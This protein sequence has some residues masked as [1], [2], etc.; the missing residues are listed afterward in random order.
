MDRSW[1]RNGLASIYVKHFANLNMAIGQ[2]IVDLHMKNMVVNLSTGMLVRLPGRVCSGTVC[3]FW[4]SLHPSR[5]SHVSTVQFFEC[6][7]H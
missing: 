1:N 7:P 4:Q 3:H 2:N 5:E 6:F